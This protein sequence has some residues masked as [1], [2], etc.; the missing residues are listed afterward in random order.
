MLKENVRTE[1]ESDYNRNT[2]RVR[3]IKFTSRRATE[4]Y[5]G[6]PLVPSQIEAFKR[7]DYLLIK[8]KRVSDDV[9]KLNVVSSFVLDSEEV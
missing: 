8:N 7:Q 1:S 5:L 2:T 3:Y 9:F 4:V 6:Y